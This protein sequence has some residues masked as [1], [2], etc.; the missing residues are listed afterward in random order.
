MGKSICDNY[1]KIILSYKRGLSASEIKQEY[2]IPLTVRSIQRY[3]KKNKIIRQNIDLINQY[4]QNKG[5]KKYWKKFHSIHGKANKYKKSNPSPK[6]R[7]MI[8]KRD[9]F[10]CV[11]CGATSENDYLVIDHIKPRKIGLNNDFSN[12]RTLCYK[13]NIGR[14]GVDY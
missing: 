5:L 6:T 7:L 12:L 14:N 9:N 8:F 13:C 11:L 10:R 2:D 4:K 1:K 3:L